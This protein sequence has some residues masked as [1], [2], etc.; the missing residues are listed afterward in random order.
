MWLGKTWLVKILIYKNLTVFENLRFLALDREEWK[1]LE[2]GRCLVS[3]LSDDFLL[4]FLFHVLL[5]PALYYRVSF[6]ASTIFPQIWAIVEFK[7]SKTILLFKT[8]GLTNF[9]LIIGDF[10]K[11]LS[12]D[13]ILETASIQYT[14]AWF[15]LVLE[16]IRLFR[17][18]NFLL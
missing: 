5:N 18:I 3:F 10:G 14:N 9:H 1:K 11:V 2:D 8:L 4:L 15:A 6:N 17:C 12:T 7:N 13:K 16:Q